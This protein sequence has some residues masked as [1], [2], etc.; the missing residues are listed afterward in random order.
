MC[1]TFRNGFP[2]QLIRK[3]NSLIETDNLVPLTLKMTIHLESEVCANREGWWSPAVRD[4][5]FL[6]SLRICVRMLFSCECL[7]L[8]FTFTAAFSSSVAILLSVVSILIFPTV[9]LW[10]PAGSELLQSILPAKI[11]CVDKLS[12]FSV[13]LQLQNNTPLPTTAY[14][15][16]S[17][18]SAA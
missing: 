13:L 10:M 8:F 12:L 7:I 5:R 9:Y 15:Y 2:S 3:S 6:G 14:Y 4:I 18:G 16:I 1:L 17:S 11:S